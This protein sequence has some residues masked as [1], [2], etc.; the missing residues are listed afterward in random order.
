M[1][2]ELE[3]EEEVSSDVRLENHEGIIYFLFPDMCEIKFPGIL[4][5]E[6]LKSSG[7]EIHEESNSF[8]VNFHK[9]R[10]KSLVLGRDPKS[11]LHEFFK[12]NKFTASITTSFKEYSQLKFE[13]PRTVSRNH[14][15]IFEKYDRFWLQNTSSNSFCMITNEKNDKKMVHP[16]DTVLLRHSDTIWM[17]SEGSCIAENT[18]YLRIGIEAFP[19]LFEGQ[20]SQQPKLVNSGSDSDSGSESSSSTDSNS[21]LD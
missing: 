20:I 17:G 3:S 15:L 4:G 14:L 11:K 1:S 16:S 21:N 2:S 12:P 9:I 6:E 13:C 5:K 7:L 19:K 10:D 8:S 18:I